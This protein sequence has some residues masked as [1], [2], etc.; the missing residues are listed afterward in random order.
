MQSLKFNVV[1]K[2]KEIKRFEEE[3][4]VIRVANKEDKLFCGSN[5]DRLNGRRRKTRLEDDNL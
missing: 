4:G 1:N 2:G 3:L 5:L